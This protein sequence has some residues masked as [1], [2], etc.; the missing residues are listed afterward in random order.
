L[1][2]ETYCVSGKKCGLLISKLGKLGNGIE[3]FQHSSSANGAG[4]CGGQKGSWLTCREMAVEHGKV[5]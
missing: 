1:R 5:F 4:T 3:T 2:E